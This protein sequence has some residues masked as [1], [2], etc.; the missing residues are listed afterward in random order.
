MIGLETLETVARLEQVYFLYLAWEG[1]FTGI[2]ADYSWPKPRF[3]AD[4][5]KAYKLSS[6]K[7]NIYSGHN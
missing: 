4:P 6:L 3:A 7:E 1:G 2:T 5:N